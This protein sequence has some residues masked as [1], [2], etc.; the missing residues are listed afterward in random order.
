M[1][2]PDATG[3]SSVSYYAAISVLQDE[4]TSL[5]TAMSE[6]NAGIDDLI[7]DF[8]TAWDEIRDIDEHLNGSNKRRR[9]DDSLEDPD[10]PPTK[11]HKFS[12]Q[13][14]SSSVSSS[15]Q[16]RMQS[17]GSPAPVHTEPVQ[18]G[19]TK[20]NHS[21]VS[22]ANRLMSHFT[23]FMKDSIHH[24]Q[25][26]IK[27][28]QGMRHELRNIHS[29]AQEQLEEA[30]QV[31]ARKKM[32][33]QSEDARLKASQDSE[34]LDDVQDHVHLKASATAETSLADR[35]RKLETSLTSERMTHR[36]NIKALEDRLTALEALSST[37]SSHGGQKWEGAKT[38]ATRD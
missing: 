25:S 9:S 16:Y 8:D 21:G 5:A 30:R 4:R 19:D 18:Q 27:E 32:Q 23:S 17:E 14:R 22:R 37:S 1:S 26:Q 29:Q 13:P 35:L 33:L 2:H 24:K 12:P 38:E 10:T 31:L 7:Q 3:R 34:Q 28:L 11:K 20:S 15:L 36:R 6:L